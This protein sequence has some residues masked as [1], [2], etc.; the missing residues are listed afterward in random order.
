MAKIF[1]AQKRGFKNPSFMALCSFY[2]KR[3]R[4]FED[5]CWFLFKVVIVQLP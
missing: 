1:L 5:T 2:S 3:F 4:I